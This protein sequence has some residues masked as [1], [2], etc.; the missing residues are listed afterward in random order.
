MTVF[1]SCADKIGW[2]LSIDGGMAEIVRS[3]GRCVEKQLW[4]MSARS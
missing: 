4:S 3:F 2:L 1:G